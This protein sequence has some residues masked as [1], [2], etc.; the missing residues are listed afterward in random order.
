[1][2]TLIEKGDIYF[3]DLGETVGSEQSGMRPVLIVQNNVGNKHSPTLIVSPLTTKNKK[4]FLPTHVSLGNR[5]G[6]KEESIVLLEQIR[7]IDRIR[8][9]I[10]IG[11]ID[12][13]TMLQV[14][15]AIAVSFGLNGQ[16]GG[17]DEV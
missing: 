17:K 14:D 2:N 6:L 15:A 13:P 3:A 16:G 7:T 8:L 1:M 11:K 9:G 10:Y 12:Q 5:F 4:M